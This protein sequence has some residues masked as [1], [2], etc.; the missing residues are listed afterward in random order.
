LSDEVVAADLDRPETLQAAFA[1]A[2]GVFV[3]TNAWEPGSNEAIQALAAVDAAKAAGVQ[4]FIW[5]TLPNVEAI[6]QGSIKVPHFTEKAEVERFVRDAG[7]VHHTFVVAPFYYQNLL[8]AMG[9]QKQADG[10][11]NWAFPIDPGKRVVHMGDINEIGRVVA[12]AFAQ[13]EL[14]GRGE[15]LPLVGD[16]MSFNEIVGPLN[17]QDN[18]VTFTQVPRDT[19]AGWFPGAD[20]VAAMLSYFEAHTYLES[21]SGQSIALANQVAGQAPTRFADWAKANSPATN[22][23]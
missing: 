16:F 23:A 8:G 2:Y 5:S 3:V 22:T 10:T 4:H 15:H 17:S 7:F 12:G 1:G 19:F 13:P 14:A 20:D 6:S 21:H 11:L 18:R 9:P